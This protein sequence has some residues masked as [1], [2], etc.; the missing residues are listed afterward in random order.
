MSLIA[1]ATKLSQPFDDLPRFPE[2]DS[3]PSTVRIDWT[4]WAEI[5]SEL[6]SDGLK[7]GEEIHVTDADVMTMSKKMTDDYLDWYQN[8]WMDDRR[9]KSMGVYFLLNHH[10]DHL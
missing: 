5:M 6:P 1:V 9:P 2:S 7:R 8:N 10:I 3:D 4:K